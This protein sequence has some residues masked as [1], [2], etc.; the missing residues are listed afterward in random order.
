MKSEYKEIHKQADKLMHRT[1]AMVDDRSHQAAAQV[2]K[3]AR[4]VLETIESDRPP[5]SIEDQIKRM[6]QNLE[7]LKEHPEAMTPSD[8]ANLEDQYEDLR[9]DSRS[10]PGY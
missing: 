8:T 1:N 10:L 6:Q 3:S 5:R 4:D 7:R 2:M 9:R